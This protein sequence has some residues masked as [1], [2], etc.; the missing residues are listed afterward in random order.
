MIEIEKVNKFYGTK[1]ILEDVS[2][3]IKP[4]ENYGF[5]WREWVWENEFDE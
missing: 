2:F 1:K 3:S 5:N 4:G